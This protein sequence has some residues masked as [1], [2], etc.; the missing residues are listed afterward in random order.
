MWYTANP[1]FPAVISPYLSRGLCSP[2]EKV[3]FLP[4]AHKLADLAPIPKT[5]NASRPDDIR[6][7]S[8]T[9]IS[10]RLFEKL[11][12]SK[13][14]YILPNIVRL[15]DT[16][17]FIYRPQL[18]TADYLLTLQYYPQLPRS[19]EPRWCPHNCGGLL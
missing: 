19:T 11:A 1:F 18:S 3:N 2:L 9:P 8:I 4:L 10:A 6:G 14:M 17:Q 5:A 7:M 15:G 13:Y 12:H 16:L